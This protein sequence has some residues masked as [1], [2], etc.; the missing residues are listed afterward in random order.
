MLIGFPMHTNRYIENPYS[1]FH[2]KLKLE[3]LIS[4]IL[5]SLNIIVYIRRIL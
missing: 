2:Y 1:F 5:K 3:I 4:K